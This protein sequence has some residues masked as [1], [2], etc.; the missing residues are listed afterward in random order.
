MPSTTAVNARAGIS[1]TSWAP[2]SAKIASAPSRWDGLTENRSTN[3]GASSTATVASTTASM[4]KKASV[5]A[6]IALIALRSP[7]CSASAT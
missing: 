4:V 6:M 3:T 5:V 7:S 2:I 1:K